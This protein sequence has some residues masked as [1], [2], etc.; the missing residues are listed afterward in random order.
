MDK[1]RRD[2]LYTTDSSVYDARVADFFKETILG[3]APKPASA[4]K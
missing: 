2:R 3:I 1:T 4:K